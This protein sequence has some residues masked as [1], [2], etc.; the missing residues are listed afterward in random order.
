LI[1]LFDAIPN[2]VVRRGTRPD[3]PDWTAIDATALAMVLGISTTIGSIFDDMCALT[4]TADV[5]HC[6]LNHD[7]N[8]NSS[9]TT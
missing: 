3:I 9:L 1:S 8:Y 6:F 4:D 7:P 2:G 5:Y